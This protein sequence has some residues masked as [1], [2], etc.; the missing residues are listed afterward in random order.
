VEIRIELERG[1]AMNQAIRGNLQ[2]FD[3]VDFDV[4]HFNARLR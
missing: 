2:S 4:A 3:I 1:L